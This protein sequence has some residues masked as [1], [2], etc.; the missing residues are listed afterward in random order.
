MV[1]R[2]GR[3]LGALAL[4][5]AFSLLALPRPAAAGVAT[6]PLPAQSDAQGTSNT[7]TTAVPPTATTAP[8]S[9]STA[10]ARPKDDKLLAQTALGVTFFLGLT[11]LVVVA[12][13]RTKARDG[14]LEALRQGAGNISVIPVPLV[15]GAPVGGAP[16]AETVTV[17]PAS[18]VLVVGTTVEF[19]ADKGPNPQAVNWTFDP[20]D[21]LKAAPAAASAT[22]TVTAEKPGSVKVK[23]DGE[24]KAT[25]QVVAAPAGSSI[26]FSALGP[27]IATG[28]V[29]L[30]AIGG[31]IALAFRGD[32][33]GD[34]ATLLGVAVGAGVTGTVAAATT[35]KAGASGQGQSGPGG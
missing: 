4:M 30:L 2:S 20:A 9:T 34:V 23:A 26:S 1:Q 19:R 22:V 12:I 3:L 24:T 7:K 25:A 11:T 27:G 13:D 29:A 14:E 31:A 8:G 35:G 28:L 32:F 16:A 18:A 5:S 33:T 17:T 6:T 15:G 21:I 10:R